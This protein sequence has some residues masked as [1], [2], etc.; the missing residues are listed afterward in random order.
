MSLLIIILEWIL[1]LIM[2]A[3]IL[4]LSLCPSCLSIVKKQKYYTQCPY[5]LHT[6]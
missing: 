5:C 4:D 2:V 6:W 3:F 1:Y